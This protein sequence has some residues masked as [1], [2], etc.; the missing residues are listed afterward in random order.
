MTPIQFPEANKVFGP[1]PGLT[2]EQVQSVPAFVGAIL[3]G[4]MDGSDAVVVAW[5][6]D[7][8]EIQAIVDGSPIFMMSIGGL[9]PH[10]LS[11]R[12]QFTMTE[13]K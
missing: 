1:P 13:R 2:E 6:P 12:G 7:A 10:A 3:A 4:P 5:Q 8:E 9:P 11:V